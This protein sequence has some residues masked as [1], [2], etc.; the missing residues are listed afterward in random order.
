MPSR[1]GTRLQAYVT[2]R[3]GQRSWDSG[4]R[5]VH[6]PH[7]AEPRGSRPSRFGGG[8]RRGHCYERRRG[9]ERHELRGKPGLACEW[10]SR[11]REPAAA[12][13]AGWFLS[14][15]VE[16]LA[17]RL[18]TSDDMAGWRAGIV[19]AP[20]SPEGG[21]VMAGAK[22]ATKKP[23]VP[24]APAGGGVRGWGRDGLGTG[25]RGRGARA[26]RALMSTTRGPAVAYWAIGARGT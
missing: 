25:A 24:A 19:K 23:A 22:K 4:R 20:A 26:R 2:G 8:W 3:P 7:S 16:D 13:D 11:R 18:E 12:S 10:R 14:H 21:E 17:A 6:D 15:A 1:D 9:F 5:H